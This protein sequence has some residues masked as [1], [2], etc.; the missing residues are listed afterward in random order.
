MMADTDEREQ[1]SMILQQANKL[2]AARDANGFALLVTSIRPFLVSIPKAKAAKLVRVLIDLFAGI[3]D[4][5]SMQVKVCQDAIQWATQESRVYLKQSLETRLAAM[6]LEN[7]MYPDALSLIS[8]LLQ[9]LKRL[10]DKMVLVDVYLLESKVYHAIRNIAKSKASLTSARTTANSIYCPPMQQ[11]CLDMQSGIL[12]AEEG[13]FKT[14][15]SYFFE[16]LEGFSSIEDS[17]AIVALKYMLLCKLMLN[18][19]DDIDALLH[20]KIA[21]KYVGLESEAMKSISTALKNRSLSDFENTIAQYKQQLTMDPVIHRHLSTIYNT[22]LE[23]NLIRVVEPFSRVEIEHVASLVK[24]PLGQVEQKLS[25]L[26]LDKKIHGILDQNAAVLI[27]FEEPKKDE[28]YLNSIE[29]IKKMGTVVSSLYS[30][31]SK[32]S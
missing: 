5:M 24:L 2:V 1:E 11:A 4:S 7:K 31:A 27:T 18:Q 10:D 8:R 6:F 3:P 12:N 28:T 19:T 26:I 25:Q 13:D 30:K 9:E 29:T 23:Q 20:Q 22:L 21:S 17:R 15:Y 14:A 32:L 16:T